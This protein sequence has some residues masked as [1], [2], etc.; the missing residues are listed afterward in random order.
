MALDDK[1][2]VEWMM[3]PREAWGDVEPNLLSGKAKAAAKDEFRS[4]AEVMTAMKDKLYGK[5]PAYTKVCWAEAVPFK[6][7]FK[8]NLGCQ[9][10]KGLTVK[11]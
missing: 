3:S 6:R 9:K 10:V 1:M 4:T 2:A 7:I 5:D 11:K 8:R